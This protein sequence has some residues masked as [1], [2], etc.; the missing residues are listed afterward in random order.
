MFTAIGIA[1]AGF[2]AGFSRWFNADVFKA[3]VWAFAI[4]SILAAIAWSHGSG[5]KRGR[6]QYEAQVLADTNR[7]NAEIAAKQAA[8]AKRVAQAAERERAAYER[9]LE[10]A[11]DRAASLERQLAELKQTSGDPVVLPRSLARELNK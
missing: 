6:A 5:L 10:Q 4:V 8:E 11:L 1:L 3:C 9:D 7:R 2:K